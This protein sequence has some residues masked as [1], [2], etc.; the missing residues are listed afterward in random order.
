MM[1]DLSQAR[2][3]KKCIVYNYIVIQIVAALKEVRVWQIS[4][5]R[6]EFKSYETGWTQ[7]SLVW[8]NL[9]S[10][11]SILYSRKTEK[12][13]QLLSSKVEQVICSTNY[14]QQLCIAMQFVS[15]NRLIL[16]QKS[17]VEAFIQTIDKN[18]MN[19]F[20]YRQGEEERIHLLLSVKL[21]RYTPQVFWRWP[22]LILDL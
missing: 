13:K 4:D 7:T 8:K 3:K 14:R 5:Q 6:T 12:R 11:N 16:K 19:F 22:G 15:K 10:E 20:A 17:A 21:S 1:C 2:L 18:V 9:L